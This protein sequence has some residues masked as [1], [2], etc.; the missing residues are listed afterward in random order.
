MK[1]MDKLI[2]NIK[3]EKK[4]VLFT[5]IIVILGI[6]TGSLFIVILNYQIKNMLLLLRVL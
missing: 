5:L 1:I 4:Y 3:F 2:D 6:I